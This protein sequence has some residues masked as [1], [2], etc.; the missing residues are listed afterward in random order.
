MNITEAPEYSQCMFYESDGGNVHG[1]H[2]ILYK[3]E[4]Q[5]KEDTERAKRYILNQQEALSI[6]VK[7][8]TPDIWR[9]AI[10]FHN[11]R[12]KRLFQ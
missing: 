4:D 12:I 11:N 1:M 7:D 5:S 2:F 8:C 6:K 9:K 10:K 3:G